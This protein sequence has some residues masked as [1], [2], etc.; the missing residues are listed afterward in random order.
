MLN[1]EGLWKHGWKISLK[2]HYYIY[3]TKESKLWKQLNYRL[4]QQFQYFKHYS[5]I[6]YLL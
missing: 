6:S 3:L 2:N 1:L 4:K 5:N